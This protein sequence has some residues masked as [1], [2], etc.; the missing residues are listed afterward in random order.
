M[1]MLSTW[2]GRLIIL[3]LAFP[4]VMLGIPFLIATLRQRLAW[5]KRQPADAQIGVAMHP[6]PG[7][8]RDPAIDGLLRSGDSRRYTA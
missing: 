8:R 1:D 2:T 5:D 6:T 7:G 3:L 4:V